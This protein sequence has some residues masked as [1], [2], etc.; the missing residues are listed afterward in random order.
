MER[1]H[2]MNLLPIGIAVL[3]EQDPFNVG[4]LFLQ[5]SLFCLS[6]FYLSFFCSWNLPEV[7]FGTLDTQ[8]AS[9]LSCCRRRPAPGSTVGSSNRRN[10]LKA[11][12][13]EADRTGKPNSVSATSMSGSDGICT[14]AD[15]TSASTL[16]RSSVCAAARMRG[17]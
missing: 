14:Q 8:L 16:V 9:R 6:G 13:V 11:V 1:A 17:P 2:S 4:H 5:S 3:V 12:A 7:V 10:K 15:R